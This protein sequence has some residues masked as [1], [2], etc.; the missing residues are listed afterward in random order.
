MLP[1]CASGWFRRVLLIGFAGVVVAAAASRGDAAA[2]GIRP[3]K[4]VWL[5]ENA[6]LSV[7]TSQRRQTFA[8]TGT[9]KEGPDDWP[10]AWSPDGQ[11]IAFSRSSD[12]PGIYIVRV[13]HGAA[14]AVR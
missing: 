1:L 8:L 12:Q 4:V 5:R 6:G 10:A 14:A 7:W 13:G 9:K 11:Y 3:W 2:T